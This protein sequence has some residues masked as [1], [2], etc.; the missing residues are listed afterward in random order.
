MTD[1]YTL[2]LD[3]AV[4][5]LIDWGDTPHPAARIPAAGELLSLRLEHPDSDVVTRQLHTLGANIVASQAPRYRMI[6][7]IGSGAGIRELC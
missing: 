5:F 7:T 2:P 3:G 4:P 6:A 1:P